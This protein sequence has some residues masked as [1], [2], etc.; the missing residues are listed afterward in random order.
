MRRRGEAGMKCPF[1]FKE[2]TSDEDTQRCQS[3]CALL[4]RSDRECT[5][6]HYR[7]VFVC[8]LLSTQDKKQAVNRL[9]GEWKKRGSK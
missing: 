3:D 8:G 4:V 1:R 7:D 5:D 2:F 9:Y 6:T